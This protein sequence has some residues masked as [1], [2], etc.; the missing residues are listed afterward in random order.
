MT[1]Q[2]NRTEFKNTND[3]YN[4]TTICIDLYRGT[5]AE[6]FCDFVLEELKKAIDGSNSNFE[7]PT[8]S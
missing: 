4:R 1:N 7:I 8:G 6:K 3:K 2:N 5:D